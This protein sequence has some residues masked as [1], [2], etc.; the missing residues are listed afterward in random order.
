MNKT[1]NVLT[2]MILFTT[3][4]GFSVIQSLYLLFN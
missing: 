3:F 2:Y 1:V 4:I